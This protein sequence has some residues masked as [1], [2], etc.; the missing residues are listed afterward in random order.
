MRNMRYGLLA[1]ALAGLLLVV[2]LFFDQ[3]PGDQLVLVAQS[4][5]LDGRAE[6][7]WVAAFVMFV[8]GVIVGGVFGAFRRQRPNTRGR[9]LLWGWVVGVLWWLVLFVFLGGVVERV[10]FSLYTLLLYLV[11]SLLYGLALGSLYATMQQ[12]ASNQA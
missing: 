6:S 3:G 12:G 11:L 10:S 9:S 2:L 1:G 7:K 8:L 4:L 5:G